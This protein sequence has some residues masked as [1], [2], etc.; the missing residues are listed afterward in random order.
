[1]FKDFRPNLRSPETQPIADKQEI[2]RLFK[3]GDFTKAHKRCKRAGFALSGFKQAIEIGAKK[4]YMARRAGELLSFIYNTGITVQ[5]DNITLLRA[6]FEM[7]DYHGFL[8][9]AHRFEVFCGIESEIEVAIGKLIEKRQAADAE[10]WRRK[11][12]L[13]RDSAQTK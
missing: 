4:A 3:T 9:Q 6:M 1:M 12:K 10:G 5:Y 7:T 13:L 2:E 11:F 8:K